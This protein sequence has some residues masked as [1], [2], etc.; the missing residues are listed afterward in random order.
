MHSLKFHNG[1]I[2]FLQQITTYFYMLFVIVILFCQYSYYLMH[3]ISDF[4]SVNYGK[5]KMKTIA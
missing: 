1:K 5:E 3:S 2:I 4:L